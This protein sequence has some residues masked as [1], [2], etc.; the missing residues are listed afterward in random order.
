MKEFKIAGAIGIKINSNN[1]IV[2]TSSIETNVHEY[3]IIPPDKVQFITYN[4]EEIIRIITNISLL[5]E[6][7]NSNMARSEYKFLSDRFGSK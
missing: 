2:I 5:F 1:M 3:H 4:G 7:G 6:F